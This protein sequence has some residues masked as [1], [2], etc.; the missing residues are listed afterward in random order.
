[1]E[2]AITSKPIAE[3]PRSGVPT[4]RSS[5]AGWRSLAF[6]DLGYHEFHASE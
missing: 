5:S 3:C 2:G 4:D 1:M 6:G